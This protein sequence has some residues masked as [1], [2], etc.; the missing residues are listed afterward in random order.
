MKGDCTQ[1]GFEHVGKVIFCAKVKR[2]KKENE[3]LEAEDEAENDA[4]TTKS[5]GVDALAG[6][7]GGGSVGTWKLS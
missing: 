6:R 4:Q 2:R 5:M 1:R 3:A 7:K